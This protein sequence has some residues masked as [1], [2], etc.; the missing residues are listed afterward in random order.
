MIHMLKNN[1]NHSSHIT[2]IMVVIAKLSCYPNKITDFHCLIRVN[3]FVTNIFSTAWMCGI[4]DIYTSVTIPDTGSAQPPVP[5]KSQI[6][7][8]VWADHVIWVCLK[9]APCVAIATGD[10]SSVWVLEVYTFEVDVY[11]SDPVVVLCI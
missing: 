5:H 6:T 2:I 4:I 8:T 7:R 9:Q 1:S 3:N 11:V 10:W